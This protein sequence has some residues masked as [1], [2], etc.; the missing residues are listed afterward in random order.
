[1]TLREGPLSPQELQNAEIQWVKE[2]QKSLG[3]CLKK[4]KVK[5]LSP[6]TDPD[7]TVRV[8]FE[9]TKR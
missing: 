3:D 2:S 4:R 9:Q 8:A 6:Y 1:M 7:G 5:N